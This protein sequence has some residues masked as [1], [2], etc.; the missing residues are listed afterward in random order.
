MTFKC[1]KGY[2]DMFFD[3]VCPISAESNCILC[4]LPS[5]WERCWRGF[6]ARAARK[7]TLEERLNDSS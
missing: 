5:R 1:P 7:Q 6:W 2:G 3:R 4:N